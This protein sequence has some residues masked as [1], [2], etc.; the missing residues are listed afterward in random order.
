[1]TYAPTLVLS[2]KNEEIKEEYYRALDETIRRISKRN[3]LIIAGDF[4]AE[5]GRP[6]ETYSE[7]MGRYGKGEMNSNGQYLVEFALQNQLY[8]TNTR[9]KH[10]MS[11]WTIWTGPERKQEFKDKNG[12]DQEKPIQKSNALFFWSNGCSCTFGILGWILHLLQ[13]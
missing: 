5:V 12:R 4:N 7:C 9:F 2:E 11:H 6:S 3:L 13:I 10:K 8:I 1:M